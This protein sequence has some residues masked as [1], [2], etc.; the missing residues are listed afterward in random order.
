MSGNWLSLTPTRKPNVAKPFLPYGRQLIDADDIQ[1]VVDVLSSDY[2]T[3]GPLVAEFETAFSTAIDAPYA[4]ACSNGTTALHLAVLAA[5]I[6]PGD[7]VI[8]PSVTFLATANAVRYVGGEV[9]FADVD[10]ETGLLRPEDIDA[11]L[12]RTKGARVKAALPVHLGGQVADPVAIGSLAKDRELIVIEDAC[13]ALGAHYQDSEGTT[14]TVGSCAHSDFATFSFHPVKTMATGEGGAI[15]C[16]DEAAATRMRQLHNHGMVRDPQNWSNT[17]DGFDAA[18][19]PNVWYYEMQE[20]GFNFRLTDIQCALGLSQLKKLTHFVSIREK[21][22][23]TYERL[24]GNL[25]LPIR[26][27]PR[28]PNCQ[29]GWHLFALL[30]DFEAIGKDRNTVM[31]A[32]RNAQ[33]GTQVHY[34]PV[35]LQPY[36]RNRYGEID[37]PGA[38]AYYQSTMSLPLFPS[39]TDDDVAFVVDTLAA[40]L[41]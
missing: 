30:V 18:G 5:G 21:L 3:T 6:G 16:R 20:L 11:A 1:A 31:A 35:H 15:A 27:V 32:L 29:A 19:K 26:P 39:M 7:H 10:P 28:V 33:I 25:D 38:R 24:I 13:H 17:T 8:V 2:L 36:Y 34:I 14:F 41:A 22:R 12:R 9:I 40:E 23:Q 37:L 4:V